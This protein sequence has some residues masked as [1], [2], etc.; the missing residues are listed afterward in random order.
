MKELHCATQALF[1]SCALSFQTASAHRPKIPADVYVGGLTVDAQRA[2]LEAGTFK[3]AETDAALTKWLGRARRKG[4]GALFMWK[5]GNYFW[6]YV[7]PSHGLDSS[8]LNS[9]NADMRRPRYKDSIQVEEERGQ[10]K[11]IKLGRGEHGFRLIPVGR[12]SYELGQSIPAWERSLTNS[13][14]FDEWALGLDS[15]SGC[16][17]G[18]MEPT[19][20]VAIVLRKR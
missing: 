14:N 10:W 2:R 15:N 20:A 17:T 4:A 16:L 8:W 3:S 1:I 18:K 11:P 19:G 13:G 6:K 9:P 12:R 7:D 5:N